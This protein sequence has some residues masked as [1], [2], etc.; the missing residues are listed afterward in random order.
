MAGP[1][2]VESER[3]TF[4]WRWLG[5]R[6]PSVSCTASLL[7]VLVRALLGA[8][9][10]SAVATDKLVGSRTCTILL[11]SPAGHSNQP[12]PRFLPRRG[13]HPWDEGRRL[14]LGSRGRLES[15]EKLRRLAALL[16]NRGGRPSLKVLQA[17]CCSAGSL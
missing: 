11:S 12:P 9:P 10:S 3:R 7:G 1:S 17:L 4:L 5:L 8:L 13:S 6:L 2:R 14:L 16:D 15:G